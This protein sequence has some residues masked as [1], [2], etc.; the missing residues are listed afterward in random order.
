MPRIPRKS[1]VGVGILS[2]N[3]FVC[4]DSDRIFFA[5]WFPPPEADGGLK[6]SSENLETSPHTQHTA[7]R[8]H[9]VGLWRADI[10]L[11]GSEVRE[12]CAFASCHA[13]HVF[14]SQLVRLLAGRRFG[15]KY[16]GQIVKY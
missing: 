9:D 11:R 8:F 2:G 1:N 5:H 4:K 14:A 15:M 6:A 13:C 16:N 12:S 3:F 7:G 10:R